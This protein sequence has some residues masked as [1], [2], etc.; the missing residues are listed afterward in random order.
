MDGLRHFLLLYLSVMLSGLAI[1]CTKEKKVDSNLPDPSVT[2]LNK[3][4]PLGAS[5][6]A[7]ATPE[8]E[9]YRY[10]LWKLLIDSGFEFDFVGT[11]ID[12]ATYPDYNGLRFDP[13]HQG[14]G[15]IT[16]GGIL[17][18]IDGWLEDLD[19]A[20][21]IVLFSSPGGNDGI[22]N[23]QQTA[24]NVNAI[25]DILQEENPNIT[26]YL[27]LPAPPISR[28]QTPEFMAFY[29]GALQTIQDIAEQQTTSSSKVLT[30]DMMT[31]FSDALLAD[32]VHYNASGARFVADR[33]FDELATIL[34]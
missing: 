6:V 7:G 16:S 20:P 21:D 18:E 4:L 11:E 12:N 15:G 26:I 30:I 3:I 34:R 23:Y 17:E 14:R 28:D 10:E 5:R 22:G 24:S 1:T 25:I 32:E 9:S 2:S 27:E 13:D 19:N 8:Y 29:N 31:G 33:Y